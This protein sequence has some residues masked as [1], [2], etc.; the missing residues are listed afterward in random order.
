MNRWLLGLG[1]VLALLVGVGTYAAV[2]TA[3]DLGRPLTTVVMARQEIPERTL[4]TAANVAELLATE[5]IPTEWV[6]RGALSQPQDA[7]GKV[8]TTRLAK[9]EMVLGTPDRLASG[10][11]AGARPAAAIPRD[12]VALA[13]SAT[14]AISVAGAV[15]AGDRVDVIGTWARPNGQPVTQAVFQ[16]VRVFAVGRWQSDLRQQPSGTPASTV[17]L[18]LDHQQ[19][20]VIENL[21]QTGARVSLALRRLDQSGEVPTEPVTHDLL[22]RGTFELEGAP[23]AR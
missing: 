13:L 16:D 10:E 15:Q 6:P 3:Q 1:I 7:I 19:A 14:D 4:L 17:T 20:L 23:A 22:A 2:T 18:L 12:K 11:G 9:G 5:Q 21:V 8:T